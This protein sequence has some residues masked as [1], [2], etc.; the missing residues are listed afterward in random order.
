MIPE[1]SAHEQKHRKNKG[2]VMV[3]KH[4]RIPA[5]QP[6]LETNPLDCRHGSGYRMAQNRWHAGLSVGFIATMDSVDFE[7]AIARSNRL[8]ARHWDEMKRIS[9]GE[10]RRER[11]RKVKKAF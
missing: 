5:H 9:R 7:G 2:E 6:C 1:I 3:P 11:R 10:D 4:Q 8:E